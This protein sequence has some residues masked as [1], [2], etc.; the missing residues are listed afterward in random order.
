MLL[1]LRV[2]MCLLSSVEFLCFA[3]PFDERNI[4]THAKKS[5]LIHQQ[6]FPLSGHE[7]VCRQLH[8]FLLTVSSLGSWSCLD[9][10]KMRLLWLSMICLVLFMQL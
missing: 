5:I 4:I 7:S 8:D 9:E 2:Q 3:C 6:Q 10:C 1:S